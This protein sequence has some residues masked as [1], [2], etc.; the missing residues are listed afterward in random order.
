MADPIVLCECGE[1]VPVG[2]SWAMVRCPHC[3]RR[4]LRRDYEPVVVEQ[5]PDPVSH[6]AHYTSHPSGV[7]CINREIERRGRA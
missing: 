2:I 1:A 3:S 4:L 7:E 6:P 5:P